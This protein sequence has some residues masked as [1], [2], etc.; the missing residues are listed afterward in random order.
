MLS[1]KNPEKFSEFWQNFQTSENS[2]IFQIVFQSEILIKK[3]AAI[4]PACS[5]KKLVRKISDFFKKNCRLIF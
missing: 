4:L 3:S 5:T 2:Q 1:I